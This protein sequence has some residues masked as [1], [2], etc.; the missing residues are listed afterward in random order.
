MGQALGWAKAYNVI[1]NG[2]QSSA[3][4]VAAK[5]PSGCREFKFLFET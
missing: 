5:K 3:Y 4:G 2:V 1:Y